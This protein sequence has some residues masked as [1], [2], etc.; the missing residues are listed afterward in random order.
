[1]E[2]EKFSK[3]INSL[4]SDEE[5]WQLFSFV[6]KELRTRGLIRSGNIVGD[7]GEFIAVNYYNKIS[8]LAKL[9]IAPEGTQNV[10]ALSRKGERYSIKTITE[11][12]VTTGVFYGVGNLG[13]KELPE[14]KF[15]YVIIVQ[16]D[17]GYM[18]KRI[19]ELSW[20]QFL[21]FRK[22]HKTMRAWNISITK[23]LLKEAR[24]I[25]E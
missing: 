19:I 25:Y 18:P 20:S 21:K 17:K 4:S 15:E 5:F 3:I 16:I 23:D 10:D 22:W 6:Q 13:D 1:M 12:S 14:K 8:G 9:Q 24:M 11:P 7:R 2:N